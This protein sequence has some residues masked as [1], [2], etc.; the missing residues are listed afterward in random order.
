[1]LTSRRSFLKGVLALAATA[2]LGV[3]EVLELAKPIKCPGLE[4]IIPPK[5]WSQYMDV[6][7]ERSPSM[8][9]VNG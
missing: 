8:R 9:L 7:K 4:N 6:V 3:N 1:M 5:L 2:C